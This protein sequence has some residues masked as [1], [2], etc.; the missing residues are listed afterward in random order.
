M[1]RTL[2][3]N[4]ESP[5]I[6]KQFHG[7]ISASN[8]LP[9]DYCEDLVHDEFYK[10]IISWKSVKQFKMNRIQHQ[11][12]KIWEEK[13]LTWR[14]KWNMSSKTGGRVKH[15]KELVL[16][17]C[18]KIRKTHENTKGQSEPCT[19]LTCWPCRLGWGLLNTLTASLQSG[20]TP[21]PNKCPG[22]DT[23]QSDGEASV[24]LELWRMRSTPSLPLLPGSL[25]PWLVATNRVLS[26]G[27]IE[28][29]NVLTLNLIVWNRTIFEI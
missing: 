22:Y 24:I 15:S 21:P 3:L 26:M 20:K 27:Q 11:T 8:R 18:I 7:K 25:L 17:D 2:W 19:Q 1:L 13:I 23:K 16:W 5:F 12:T 14:I 28:L 6:I 10:R 9:E 4:K 29:N